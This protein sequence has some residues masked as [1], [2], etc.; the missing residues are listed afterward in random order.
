[1]KKISIIIPVYNCEKYISAAIES[2]INQ[3]V[4]HLCEMIIVNE[5]NLHKILKNKVYFSREDADWTLL[6]QQKKEK[7]DE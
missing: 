3:P 7:G 4:F 5:Y 6:I 1:M 2:I